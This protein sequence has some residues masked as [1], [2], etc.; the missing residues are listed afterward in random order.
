MFEKKQ[1]RTK[2]EE[3]IRMYSG[4]F[5]EDEVNRRK[6]EEEPSSE[7]RSFSS[8]V[9]LLPEIEEDEDILKK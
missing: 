2:N 3:E 1:N 8:P 6:T 5:S 7:P 9:C 4:C